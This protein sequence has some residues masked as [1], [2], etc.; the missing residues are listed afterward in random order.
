LC[1]KECTVDELDALKK[2]DEKDYISLIGWIP[3]E[4]YNGG[5]VNKNDKNFVNY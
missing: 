3:Y 5:D 4:F 2:D 1:K